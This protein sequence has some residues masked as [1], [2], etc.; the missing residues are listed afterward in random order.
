MSM[1]MTPIGRDAR[2]RDGAASAVLVR[3]RAAS[4]ILGADFEPKRDSADSGE[5]LRPIFRMS[6]ARSSERARSVPP[7]S[8]G[9]ASRLPFD[10]KT[11]IT[12]TNGV[13]ET[14]AL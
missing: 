10:D 6:I 7:G 11:Y 4:P 9:S 14:R 2:E 12:Y 13:Y 5:P 1:Y 8:R 3:S